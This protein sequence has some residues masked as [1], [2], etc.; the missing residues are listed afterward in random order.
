MLRSEV[1]AL[2]SRPF[3]LILYQKFERISNF[4]RLGISCERTLHAEP[5]PKSSSSTLSI[6]IIAEF[7]KFFKFSRSWISGIFGIFRENFCEIFRANVLREQ[8]GEHENHKF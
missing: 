2:G 4:G 5:L 7:L 1:R 3:V 8:V 6:Y